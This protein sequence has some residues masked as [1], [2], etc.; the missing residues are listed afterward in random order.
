MA[1][2]AVQRIKREFKEVLKSEEV[3]NELRDIPPLSPGREGPAR[4]DSPHPRQPAGALLAAALLPAGKQASPPS[5][6]RLPLPGPWDGRSRGRAPGK[7]AWFWG[8]RRRRGHRAGAS[9]RESP[10][11]VATAG[12]G[13]AGRG[14]SRPSPRK[15]GK[16]VGGRGQVVTGSRE[17]RCSEAHTLRVFWAMACVA[18]ANLSLKEAP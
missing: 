4:G 13:A 18:S 16:W 7:G 9:P 11:A 5:F 6:R 14:G 3:R 1:N 10:E 2:I 15:P 17:A 12:S 8:G